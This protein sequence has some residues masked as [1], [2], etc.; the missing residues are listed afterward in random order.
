MSCGAGTAH[1]GYRRQ[2]QPAPTSG[3]LSAVTFPAGLSNSVGVMR[4]VVSGS[5]VTSDAVGPPALSAKRLCFFFAP[6]AELRC[7]TKRARFFF[8]IACGCV[9]LLCSVHGVRCR[10]E[11]A[12]FLLPRGAVSCAPCLAWQAFWLASF[13]V[14]SARPLSPLRRRV[15]THNRPHPGRI[16]HRLCC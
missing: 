10:T 12:S 14:D 6:L 13:S 9:A 2:R 11:R 4:R 15:R 1:P 5:L 7:Q 8:F 3:K 16:I